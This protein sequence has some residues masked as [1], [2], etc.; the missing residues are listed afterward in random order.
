MRLLTSGFVLTYLLARLSFPVCGQESRRTIDVPGLPDGDFV[1]F[2]ELL[3]DRSPW[4]VAPR[5]NLSKEVEYLFAL[6]NQQLEDYAK[7]KA[8]NGRPPGTVL[9]IVDDLAIDLWNYKHHLIMCYGLFSLRGIS[10]GNAAS[11]PKS[12]DEQEKARGVRWIADHRMPFH[13]ADRN[14][15]EIVRL[16]KYNADL[17][18]GLLRST[19]YRVHYASA[20]HAKV[21]FLWNLFQA[22]Y[23]ERGYSR[24]RLFVVL[25]AAYQAAWRIPKDRASEKLREARHTH[26]DRLQE[27]A[28]AM[29]ARR[30]RYAPLDE[31]QE[32]IGE[33]TI[34]YFRSH[35]NGS[36]SEAG[37]LINYTMRHQYFIK[38]DRDGL[39]IIKTTFNRGVE[40]GTRERWIGT[41]D[42]RTHSTVRMVGGRREG[43]FVMTLENFGRI[44]VIQN[45]RAGELHGRARYFDRRSGRPSSTEQYREGAL[46]GFRDLFAIDGPDK[47]KHTTREIWRD[48]RREKVLSML[49]KRRSIPA[50]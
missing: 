42:E 11:G 34:P 25:D 5:P 12:A 31:D 32:P 1:A 19:N 17:L 35:D 45:F 14:Y 37:V 9:R 6:P 4:F 49:P 8:K 33:R 16:Y 47:G 43:A 30:L 23:V 28:R 13:L 48:G 24:T 38:W 29:G 39:P 18:R 41:G 44:I 7:A 2:S 10:P 22:M 36:L 3:K 50:R 21:A 27:V 15:R 46:H 26:L 20:M 40:S